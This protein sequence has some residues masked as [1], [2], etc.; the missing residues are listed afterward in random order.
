[1]DKKQTEGRTIYVTA[2]PIGNLG[3]MTQRSLEILRDVDFVLCEDTRRSGLLLEHF[4]IRKK[5]VSY[6]AHNEA[7]RTDQ[8]LPRL[9]DGESAAIITDAGTPG[10]S[11]PGARIVD[12]CLEA[13]IRVC[14]VPGASAVVS[15]VSAAGFYQY[16]SF[17]FVAFFPRKPSERIALFKSFADRKTLLVGYESPQRIESLLADLESVVGAQRRICMC[18]EL[19][20]KFETIQR[21]TIG[22]LRS[23]LAESP[24][25]G[26]ICLVIEGAED[27][28]TEDENTLPESAQKLAELLISHHMS[29]KDV[30]DIVSEYCGVRPKAVYRFVLE[31]NTEN[32]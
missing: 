3:D 19:T 32:T 1:M 6:F 24:V 21:T 29:A 14:P 27:V 25:K 18:R 9:L 5:L 2:T 31:Q 20:K 30:R 26:E 22:Q 16:T 12:A 11:D 13:G 7:V 28:E 8:F 4:G 23:A 15:A 10:I 17:E